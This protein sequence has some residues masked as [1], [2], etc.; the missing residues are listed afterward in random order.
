MIGTLRIFLPGPLLLVALLV[1]GS[2]EA[3]PVN[4]DGLI[5]TEGGVSWT[6]IIFDA[7]RDL[8]PSPALQNVVAVRDAVLL[9]PPKEDAFD[10]SWEVSVGGFLVRLQPGLNGDRVIDPTGTTVT[11][12]TTTV[13]GLNVTLQFFM[14]RDLPV[15]R[16]LVILQNP[17]PSGVTV[18]VALLGD[19]GSDGDTL[20]VEPSA[21]G[22]AGLTDA[23]RWVISSDATLSDPVIGTVVFGP[24][25][26]AVRSRAATLVEDRFSV[27]YSVR[28]PPGTTRRVMGFSQLSADPAAARTAITFFDTNEAL[29]AA[30]LLSGLDAQAQAEIVNWTLGFPTVCAD[31]TGC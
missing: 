4:I 8:P 29:T 15:L 20:V 11:A 9:N 17:G 21:S 5:V 14:S 7:V 10:G 23:D 16:V 6:F 2:A 31:R 24:G 30:G 18:Q 19:L 26:P 13:A 12:A 27:S 3:E 1:A 22:D 25:G 28:V